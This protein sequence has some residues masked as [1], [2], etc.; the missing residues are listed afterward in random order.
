[1]VFTVSTKLGHSK[2]EKE[3]IAEEFFESL[4]AAHQYGRAADVIIK[5]AMKPQRAEEVISLLVKGQKFFKAIEI[6]VE[7]SREELINKVVQPAVRLA[8]ELKSK[9]IQKNIDTYKEKLIRLKIVQF[10]K[11][12]MPQ[13]TS[14]EF[15]DFDP[16]T[17]STYSGVTS[18]ISGTKSYTG[19]SSSSKRSTSSKKSMKR[20]KV[21]RKKVKEGSPFEEDFLVE[22]LNE[23]KPQ[24]RTKD[25]I[26][27]LIKILVYFEM[28]E[29][30]QNI[31]K[32]I[33][34]FVELTKKEERTNAQLD[35]IE[36][37]PDLI[38]IFPQLDDKKKQKE[39][40]DKW[41]FA[42]F[43]SH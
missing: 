18:Q 7:Y 19:S 9:D 38:D 16:E 10:N 5:H 28:L 22:Y 13:L 23:M 17:M 3:K 4:K 29:E 40:E 32:L 39:E 1:M 14:A 31:Q 36:K 8:Y 2:E 12:N 41:K 21:F 35:F 27:S 25:E 15:A 43:L 6:S 34:A 20:P 33:T 42:K 11:R 37:N 26:K 24:S 30:A